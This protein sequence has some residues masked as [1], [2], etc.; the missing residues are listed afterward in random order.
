MK[1]IKSGDP[2][3][4]RR[5]ISVSYVV[6]LVMENRVVPVSELAVTVPFPEEGAT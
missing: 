4:G 6:H 3:W 5:H 2:I 1:E